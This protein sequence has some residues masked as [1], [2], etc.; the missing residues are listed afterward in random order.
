M[1]TILIAGLAV[2]GSGSPEHQER[3]LRQSMAQSSTILRPTT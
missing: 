1:R 3:Q 2:A